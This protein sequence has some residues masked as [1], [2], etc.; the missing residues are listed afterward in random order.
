MRAMPIAAQPLL[1]AGRLLRLAEGKQALLSQSFVEEMLFWALMILVANPLPN[2]NQDG[3]SSLHKLAHQFYIAG[4][5]LTSVST[6]EAPEGGDLE[7]HG[8]GVSEK[9]A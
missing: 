6:S 9:Q 1:P 5:V 8:T 4:W 3:L 7:S 2:S